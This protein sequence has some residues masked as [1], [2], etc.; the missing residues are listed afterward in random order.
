MR[1]KF[2]RQGSLF[3]VMPRNPIARELAA[4]SEILDANPEVLDLVYRELAGTARVDH[5]REGL[6]AEQVLRAAIIKQSQNLS[7]EELAFHLSDS[8]TFRAFVRLE[9]NQF[10]TRSCLQDNIASLRES[11]WECIH[12]VILGYAQREGVEDGRR[13]RIDTTAV[14]TDIHAPTDS[15]LLRDGVRILTRWLLEG[16]QYS[17]RPVYR[18]RDH[19]RVVKR[20]VLTIQHARNDEVRVRAYRELLRYVAL[21]RGYALEAIG[22][23]NDW[24]GERTADTLEARALAARMARALGL[25]DRVIDQ[26]ERRVLRG[27][28]VP[29]SQKV[30][31]FF[32]DHTDIIV[33]DR[34]QT[35]Y[36]H[37][38]CLTGGVSNL[39]L[40]LR[41]E[42]GNPAD[43]DLF[44]PLVERQVALYGRVPRQVSA[45]GG[46]ASKE[47]LRWAKGEGVEDV[48][49]AK[50]RGLRVADMV[51]STWVYRQL[52]RF[53]AGI[54]ST[55][56]ALKRA[57]GMD[58][59]PWSGWTGFQR[60][61][62]SIVV[63]HN[64]FTLA[65]LRLANAQ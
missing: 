64:L 32:E 13:V 27:E 34:R 29:A 56:S 11:T 47:N 30:V 63:S 28:K 41:V 55:I 37:K 23:L 5:G 17:P 12:A 19:R 3:H 50:R 58:R 45:D 40:D 22:V 61:L 52:K 1:R 39:V 33:K 62:W 6:S 16:K 51:R 54:E 20:R 46:F 49:F 65:R 42:R 59:C 9:V 14:E 4:V 7:Y 18:V 15:T 36:G 21:V 31:S 48:C 53:R 25:L 60:Y 35:H 2:H 10:P 38:V 8:Q 57:F 26:T 44:Q 24:E 43:S